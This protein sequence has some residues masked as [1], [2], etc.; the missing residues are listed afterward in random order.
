MS[1]DESWGLAAIY[2][3]HL[4]N[5]YIRCINGN[6]LVSATELH[7]KPLPSANLITILGSR[8]RRM[9]APLSALDDVVT[10]L[11]VPPDRREAILG[12]R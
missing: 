2:S 1:E 9:A 10:E 12:Q 5:R 4:L 6:T 11:A 3:S 8:V 7:T